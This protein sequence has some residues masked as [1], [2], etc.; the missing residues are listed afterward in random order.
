MPALWRC[1]SAGTPAC[2]SR[3]GLRIGQNA[4]ATPAQQ[5]HPLLGHPQQ[6]LSP[7]QV[8][9]L[10]RLLLHGEP[11]PGRVLFG[12]RQHS[13]QLGDNSTSGMRGFCVVHIGLPPGIG[14]QR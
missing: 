11:I 4:I 2:S 10:L 9:S 1:V 8:A 6:S 14:L 7:G 5:R 13:H 12:L 3:C